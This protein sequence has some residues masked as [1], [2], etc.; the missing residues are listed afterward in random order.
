MAQNTKIV[1]TDT[2]AAEV[3]NSTKPVLVDFWATWCG[4]CRMVGPILEDLS[5]EMASQLTIAKLDVDQ[6]S[7]IA[8]RYGVMSI[9]TM[10]MFRGGKEHARLVGAMP[11]PVLKQRIEDSLK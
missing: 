10:I 3:L 11:K 5:Q 8:M 4:P 7:E 1:T 6:E 2:F 9:P